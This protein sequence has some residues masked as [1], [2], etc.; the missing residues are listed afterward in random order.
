MIDEAEPS[1]QFV[2]EMG[3][4]DGRDDGV[5]LGPGAAAMATTQVSLEKYLRTDYE[6]DCDYVDGELEERNACEKEHSLV[7]AF[8]IKWLAGNEEQWKVRSIPGGPNGCRRP[9]CELLILPSFR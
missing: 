8:C 2:A 6:P 4:E 3:D 5:K 1:P 9:E 7:Q